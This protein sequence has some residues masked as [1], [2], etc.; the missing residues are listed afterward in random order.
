MS[1]EDGSNISLPIKRQATAADTILKE[2]FLLKS[3]RVGCE[4]REGRTR[5]RASS[6]RRG[7]SDRREEYAC[8]CACVCVREYAKKTTRLG[9]RKRRPHSDTQVFFLQHTSLIIVP[10]LPSPG[11]RRL[12][13]KGIISTKLRWFVLR[14]NA[15]TQEFF[16]DCKML[17]MAPLSCCFVRRLAGPTVSRGGS[18]CR[19][20]TTHARTHTHLHTQHGLTRA[21]P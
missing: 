17:D 11:L 8:V 5:E 16:L 2:G 3:K 14:K 18:L 7:P 21:C 9:G 12:Q 19:H 4:R 1:S 6:F 10:A 20:D 13:V 15:E